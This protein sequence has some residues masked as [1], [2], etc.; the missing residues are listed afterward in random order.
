MADESTCSV[1]G[2]ESAGHW[3]ELAGDRIFCRRCGQVRLLWE[4]A[5]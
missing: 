3:F 1:P 2:V 4:L 5:S